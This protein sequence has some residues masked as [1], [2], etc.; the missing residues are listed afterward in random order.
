MCR[1]L[2]DVLGSHDFQARVGIAL[3]FKRLLETRAD[4]GDD[5]F[6]DFLTASR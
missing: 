1:E 6:L 5:D 2:A 4:A 3:D